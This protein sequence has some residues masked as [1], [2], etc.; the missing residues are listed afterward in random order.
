[1]PF[2]VTCQ[3][4]FI[5]LVTPIVL[6]V[7]YLM[8]S[9][10][11]FVAGGTALGGL[12]FLCYAVTHL[13]EALD[14]RLARNPAP[15]MSGRDETATAHPPIDVAD[16]DQLL[17]LVSNVI[18]GHDGCAAVTH[19]E[20]SRLVEDLDADS[21]LLAEL[22]A[23]LQDRTGIVVRDDDLKAVRTV[24]DVLDVVQRTSPT[25]P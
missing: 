14:E 22:L 13:C 18:D 21:L 2:A 11:G 7:G 3:A 6:I 25:S 9:A 24:G 8:V 12:G 10:W 17:E 20:S 5:A 23:D 19:D 16:R 1:M 4:L 15:P